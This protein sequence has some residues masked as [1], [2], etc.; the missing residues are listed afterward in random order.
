MSVAQAP[1]DRGSIAVCKLQ[2]SIKDSNCLS[3]KKKKKLLK[4]GC[5]AGWL[6]DGVDFNRFRCG[7]NPC[8]LEKFQLVKIKKIKNKKN[9]GG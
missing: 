7:E 9:R 5:L 1:G 3:K 8:W 4:L 6:A 2:R